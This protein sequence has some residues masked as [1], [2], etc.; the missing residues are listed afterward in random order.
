MS[1]ERYQQVR[2]RFRTGDAV[3]W[4]SRGLLPALIRLWSDYTH[5]SLVIR[6]DEYAGLRCRVFLVEA[7]SGGLTLTL[8]SQRLAET[9]GGA[10]LFQPNGLGEEQ[11]SL[12]RA[13]ALINAARRVRYDFKGFLANML[14]HVSMDARRYFC[15]EHVWDEWDHANVLTPDVLTEEGR[16]AYQQGKAPRPGDLPRWIHGELVDLRTTKPHPSSEGYQPRKETA[17]HD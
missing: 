4:R 17:C 13:S 2:S 6:L 3:L 10:W 14:G 15:S 16:R 8:L 7:L 9:K 11:S 1:A 12:L 5:A